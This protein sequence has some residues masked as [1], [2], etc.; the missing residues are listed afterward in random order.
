ML[1]QGRLVKQTER[2]NC[3]C[4]ANGVFFLFFSFLARGVQLEDGTL[5]LDE[6]KILLITTHPE[7]WTRG[8]FF[9]VRQRVFPFVFLYG[10]P[11][12][13]LA[14]YRVPSLSWQVI[15]SRACLGKSLCPEPVLA[16]HIDLHRQSSQKGGFFICRS[17]SGCRSVAVG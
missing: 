13:V 7:Y 3:P 12:P 4:K 11:E 14:N 6:Y 15:M 2:N 16:N 17:K 5:Q 10:C 1:Y 9:Q 8:M